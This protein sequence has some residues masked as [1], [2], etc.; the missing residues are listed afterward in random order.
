MAPC[1]VSANW[2]DNLAATNKMSSA[3]SFRPRTLANIRSMYVELHCHSAFSFLDGASL[4]DELVPAALRARLPGARADRPQLGLGLDGVRRDRPRARAAADPRGGGRPRRRPASDAARRGRQGLVEP[5]PDPDPRAR[6]HAR[7]AG[8]AV[9]GVRRARGRARARR[10]TGLPERMRAAGGARRAHAPAAARGV[11]SRPA[12]DRAP[13]AVPARRPGPQPAARAGWPSGSACRASP[14]AT[15]TRTRARARRCRTRSSP[16]A[17]TR[18][19]TPQSPSGA[20]TS[21][22]CS[23]RRRRWRRALRSIR[24]RSRRRR[25][26]PSDCASTSRSDLGYR[27]PGRGGRGGDAQAGRAV[28]GAAAGPLRELA[29]E[30]A[31]H[32]RGAPAGGAEDHREAG[33]ARLLPA[34]PRHARAGPGGRGRG[35]GPRHGPGAAAARARAGVERLLDR[36]LPDRALARRPDRQRAADRALP[37]RGAGGAARHRPRLPARHQGGADPAR[38]RAL[39]ARP[40]GAGRRLPHVSRAGRDPGAGQGAGAAAGGDRAGGAGQRGMGRARGR[41]GHRERV[42][43]QARTRRARPTG[44]LAGAPPAGGPGWRGWRPR[45]T[46]SRAIC[47]STPAG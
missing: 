5:V 20:A 1:L 17:C 40:L 3:N 7:E 46:G 43:G 34:A 29:G 31:G 14:R 28:L 18:R 10:G 25:G 4:P 24:R 23:P 37:E 2:R 15:C 41:E 42:R 6:A 13:A 22:T 26:W 30:R 45:P 44:T 35:A 9:A 21:A 12:E 38:A 16:C 27:Y 33:P 36:L 8:P 32:R 19:W 11:R 39:R 47:P